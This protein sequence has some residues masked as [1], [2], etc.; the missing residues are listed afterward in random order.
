MNPSQ[1]Q[2][3]KL[4]LGRLTRGRFIGDSLPSRELCFCLWLYAWIIWCVRLLLIHLSIRLC[5][6]PGDLC[7]HDWHH[8]NV[9]G[10]WSNACYERRRDLAAGCPGWPEP[11]REVWGLK[12]AIDIVFQ[13]LASLPPLS[14]SELLSHDIDNI[15]LSM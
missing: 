3:S 13:G 8:R 5:V 12:Q 11:Y 2:A 14:D 10:D 6:L 9:R 1:S 15:L 7:Q 4:V